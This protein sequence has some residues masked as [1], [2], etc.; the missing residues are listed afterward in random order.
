[1]N[2]HPSR[3]NLLV[4]AAATGTAAVAGCGPMTVRPDTGA[5]AGPPEDV[6]SEACGAIMVGAVTE[7]AVGTWTLKLANHLIIGHDDRGLFAYSSVCTHEGCDVNRPVAGEAFCPC[8][9]S[10]YDGNGAVIMGPAMRALA[11]YALSICDGAVFVDTN[12]T[13]TASTR[14]AA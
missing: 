1:M 5:D 4:L 10:R 6:G 11:H 12:R 8:H 9:G 14:A 2:D 13:V 3:R 7:F